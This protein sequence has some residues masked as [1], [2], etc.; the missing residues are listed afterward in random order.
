MEARKRE[1]AFEADYEGTDTYAQDN[2]TIWNHH[3][4]HVRAGKAQRGGHGKIYDGGEV[5]G[6]HG[7]V[8]L[9]LSSHLICDCLDPRSL[10]QI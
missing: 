9:D 7:F 1:L 6:G 10:G 4:T 8:F 3:T 2:A 5:H